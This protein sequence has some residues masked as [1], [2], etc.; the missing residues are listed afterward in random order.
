VAAALASTGDASAPV[1]DAVKSL[2]FP[3]EQTKRVRAR[4]CRRIPGEE[5]DD[6]ER[7]L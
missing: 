1:H 4:R 2:L 3:P 7:G 5:S 6:V